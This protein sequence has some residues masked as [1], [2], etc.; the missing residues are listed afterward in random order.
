MV[1]S[2]DRGEPGG[3]LVRQDDLAR[4]YSAARSSMSLGPL[5]EIKITVIVQIDVS[6]F[7]DTLNVILSGIEIIMECH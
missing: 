1:R 5:M 6:N 7:H 2:Q 4:G 3:Y